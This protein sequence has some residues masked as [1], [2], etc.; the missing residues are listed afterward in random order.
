M[1]DNRASSE[2][3]FIGDFMF[4][5]LRKFFVFF[6]FIFCSFTL[7]S[8]SEEDDSDWFWEKEIATISFENLVNVKRSEVSGITSNYIG[9]SFTEELYSEITDRLYGLDIFEEISPYARPSIKSPDKI[10]LVF[11]VVE[12]PVI[13]D[14]VFRGN[15]QIRNN[16]LRGAVTAK[17]G[18]IYR[19][20][21]VLLEERALR[22]HYLKKGYTGVR[23]TS[24]IE[25]KDDGI[26]IV[27]QIDEGASTVITSIVF[28]GVTIASPRTLK[29]KLTLK[30]MSLFKDGAF[31][32]SSLES[33]R[34]TIVAFYQE[35]GYA[36][37]EVLDV[38]EETSL[39][40]EKNRNELTLTFIVSEGFQYNLGELVIQGN[41][42]FSTEK[43]LSLIKMKEGS[44]FNNTRM[45]E[46]IQEIVNLYAENGYMTNQ[47]FPNMERDTERRT[48]SY[49]LT[50]FEN[51]RSH[52]ENIILNGNTK[53]KDFV[54]LRELGIKEGDVFSR[55][56]LMIGLRN[57]FN[58][59]YFSSVVPEPV[60]GSEENLVDLVV[61]VEE[62]STT[63]VN[64][65]LTFSG[66]SKPDDFPISLFANLE[67]SN[68]GGQGKT[69]GADMSLAT[70]V[71]SVGV[72]YGQNWIGDKPI[73]LNASLSLSHSIENSLYN[74]FSPDG[75][76]ESNYYY[77]KYNNWSASLGT[78]L[79][80]R[81]TPK[82]AILTLTGGI[83]NSIY[84]HQY[85]GSLYVPIDT[86][87]SRSINN[88]RLVNSIWGQI[89][90]DNRDINYDPSKGWFASQRLSWYG[91]LPVVESE[92]FLRTDTKLEAYWTPFD[93]KLTDKWNLKITLAA[94]TGF[95]FLFPTQKSLFSNSNKVYIN[96]M[97]D[98]R[99]W[100]NIYSSVRG[101]AMWSNRLEARVPVVPG[102]L[103]ID[104]FLDMAAIKNEPKDLFT[105]LKL[106]DL[107]WSFGPGL[108]FLLPQFPL[109]L[110]LANTFKYDGERF[111]MYD[112]L[113]FVLS[114]STTNR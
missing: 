103:G 22:D 111:R 105:D 74:N 64:F 52:I 112:T 41:S 91:L 43:L 12:R 57:L 5:K 4:V 97:F 80:R 99:G 66:V 1:F 36:D 108:R 110:L 72:S 67:S 19:E 82:F 58:T 69:I 17:A 55:E 20:G 49:T 33:D 15:K 95:T 38:L 23:V 40:V 109:R 31:Q 51:S 93:F 37:A 63:S 44:V 53:T 9:R 94:Y 86:V 26:T 46:G 90:L 29:S 30:E 73:S 106:K 79:G 102:V 10:D 100:T 98:G 65:G 62:Q 77:Y 8:Q 96:G 83:T 35:R 84:Y 45:Q 42:I 24:S 92:F 107:Y 11:S 56:K 16:D 76:W 114:F 88:V 101:K 48:I 59:R 25:D 50:I 85:D 6:L 2:V 3:L 60:Q 28:Q 27:F 68:L 39:N 54:I 104:F 75:T 34:Q 18:D 21:D 70:D 89:S 7:F 113:K 14:I 81:W 71:Q 61:S 78:S 32:R 87:Q 47:Y 13:K